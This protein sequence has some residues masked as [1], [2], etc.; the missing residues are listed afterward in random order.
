MV[1]QPAKKVQAI[2]YRDFKLCVL[3][4]TYRVSLVP[5]LERRWDQIKSHFGITDCTHSVHALTGGFILC[6]NHMNDLLVKGFARTKFT[7]WNYPLAWETDH[8]WAFKHMDK[9][10]MWH[11][12]KL[13]HWSNIQPMVPPLNASKGGADHPKRLLN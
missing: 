8:K 10:K 4:C 3:S 5:N 2:S 12:F 9:R 7:W 11:R 13:M 1:R 6:V